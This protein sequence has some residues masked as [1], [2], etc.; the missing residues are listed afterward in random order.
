MPAFEVDKT[1]SRFQVGQSIDR[2]RNRPNTGFAVDQI[3]TASKVKPINDRLQNRPM[4]DRLASKSNNVRLSGFEAENEIQA[5]SLANE[6]RVLRSFQ[7]AAALSPPTSLVPPVQV[8]SL[9]AEKQSPTAWKLRYI[10]AR[11]AID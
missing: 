9:A 10:C 4:D 2:L 11:V 6:T 3:N 7:A 8:R 1:G 5:S